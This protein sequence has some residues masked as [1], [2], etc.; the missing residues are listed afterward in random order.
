MD[1]I[2]LNTSEKSLL[3]LRKSTCD[4]ALK[5]QVFWEREVDVS[6]EPHWAGC[7][8]GGKNGRR[9]GPGSGMGMTVQ[10]RSLDCRRRRHPSWV[11]RALASD[12]SDLPDPS[13]P[14]LP[15]GKCPRGEACPPSMGFSQGTLVKVCLAP[16][17]DAF[18]SSHMRM[19]LI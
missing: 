13:V 11:K 6:G 4:T 14:G 15:T 18:S 9:S 19:T 17:H 3:R 8:P 7:T 10:Q 2:N 1:T 16:G 5:L 12:G